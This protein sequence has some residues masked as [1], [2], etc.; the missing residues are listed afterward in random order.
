MSYFFLEGL[1]DHM[2]CWGLNLV[3]LCKASVHRITLVRREYYNINLELSSE[4]T[5]AVLLL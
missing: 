3:G 2:L 5:T 1:R 4:L